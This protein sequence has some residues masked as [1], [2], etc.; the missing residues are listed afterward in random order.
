MPDKVRVYRLR[1][2]DGATDGN[3]LA[4]DASGMDMIL[5]E[6]RG[7]DIGARFSVTVEEWDRA[8]FDALSEWE[9]W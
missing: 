6:L 4:L 3:W 8:K 1:L 2:D 7:A 9:G 5:E